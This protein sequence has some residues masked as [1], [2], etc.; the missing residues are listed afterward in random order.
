MKILNLLLIP[1]A[2]V[3]AAIVFPSPIDAQRYQPAPSTALTGVWAPNDRLTHTTLHA[4]D[5]ILGPEDADQDS[6][7]R[8]YGGQKDGKIV[9]VL[10]DGTTEVFADTGGRPLGMQ[11]DAQG[12]LIVADAA[13]GLLSINPEG[14]ITVLANSTDGVDYGFTD[15]VDIASDGKIYFSDASTRWDYHDFKKD[16]LEMQ[17]TGR[18]IV[19]DPATGQTRTLL[20][21]LYFAN[22]IAL[23]QNED[24]VLVN[25]TWKYRITRYWLA[26]PKAGTHDVF[27]DNLPGFPDGISSN[28]AGT[29]WLALYSPRNALLDGMHPY[30]WLKNQMAKL[31]EFLLPKPERYGLI[32]AIDES[33]NVLASYHDTQGQVVNAITS[34]EQAGDRLILGTLT[35]NWIG[36]VPLT[37]LTQ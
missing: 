28:R 33:A 27:I 22:G 1:T 37:S 4:K 25:E 16:A 34:V 10:A 15:D 2:L 18:L 30:P 5:A 21:Q 36:T 12:N 24:F 31:P 3:L 19:Y 7:G 13:K 8:L 11:F 14:A 32:A 17:P 20:D 29:F 26:G 23:S 9:R 6:L 35:E